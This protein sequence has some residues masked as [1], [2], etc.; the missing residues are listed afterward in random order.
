MAKFRVSWKSK[1]NVGASTYEAKNQAD[2]LMKI[3]KTLSPDGIHAPGCIIK[4][5]PIEE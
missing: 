2:I 3:M 1:M 4:V 5:V